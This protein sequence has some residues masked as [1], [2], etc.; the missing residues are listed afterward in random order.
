MSCSTRRTASLKFSSK[1]LG[2]C[3]NPT[4]EVTILQ[5]A[6]VPPVSETRVSLSDREC[7][8][9]CL[10]GR[11]EDYRLLVERYEPMLRACVSRAQRAAG[12]RDAGSVDETVH[13]S[14]V[15]AFVELRKLRKP[16]S[17]AS[18]VVGIGLRVVREGSRTLRPLPRETVFEPPPQIDEPDP[19][20]IDALIGLPPD[21][22][23][24]VLLRF[25]IG[26]SCAQIADEL[27]LPLG[28]VTKRLSRAYEML[29]QTLSR[30]NAATSKAG[31]PP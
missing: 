17:F 5:P 13:E 28:S 27:S 6:G 4:T 19:A 23:E 21:F 1:N 24:V 8:A 26:L 18:W 31:L 20:L 3:R 30:P 9:H 11:P 2:F 16:E 10:D 29:R 15:R 25:F 12:V 14:F 22:R 7:I